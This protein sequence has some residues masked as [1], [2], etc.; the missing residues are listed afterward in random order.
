MV[1]VE[2]LV[3]PARCDLIDDRH[4]PRFYRLRDEVAVWCKEHCAEPVEL[5]YKVTEQCAFHI[6]S[7]TSIADLI[8]FRLKWL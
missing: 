2:F 7:F 8:L 5:T 1:L 6:L 3:L 4:H